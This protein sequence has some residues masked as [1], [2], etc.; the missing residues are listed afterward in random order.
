MTIGCHPGLRRDDTQ[1]SCQPTN[2]C[3]R[4]QYKFWNG[5]IMFVSG[6]IN[7][8]AVRPSFVASATKLLPD[9]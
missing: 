6:S 2:D 9:R 8:H 5:W 3:T 1:S 4:F 7:T